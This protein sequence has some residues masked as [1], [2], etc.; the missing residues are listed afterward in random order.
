[1]FREEAQ[2]M[3]EMEKAK[4]NNQGLVKQIHLTKQ[5]QQKVMFPI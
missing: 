5:P 4:Y 3:G 2:N 1:M